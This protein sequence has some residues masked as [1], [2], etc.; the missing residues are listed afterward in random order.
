MKRLKIVIVILLL[1]IIIS[2]V[3][4]QVSKSRTFQFF[5]GIV[6]NISTDE[7]LVALTFDDGP[8]HNT[9]K[10]IKI[11]D[12]LDVKATFFITGRELEENLDSGNKLVKAGH[13]LGNHSYSHK[14]MIFKSPSFIQNEIETTNKLIR[15]AGY[16]GE[17]QF[18]PPYF[19]KLIILPHYLHKNHINTVLCDVEPETVLGF[20]ASSQEISNYVI[21]NSKEG[22]IIL[23]HIM[24]DNRTEALNSLEAIVNGLRE[25]GYDFATLSELLEKK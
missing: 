25:K 3:I 9:D 8:T 18:R 6:N 10:I 13:E 15:Q 7:K 1:F 4:L 21:E 22:S 23:L 16:N 17:I 11:L 20:S 12:Q 2:Y 14:R 5:G 24:Y 19:K